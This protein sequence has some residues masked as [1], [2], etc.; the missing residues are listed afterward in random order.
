MKTPLQDLWDDVMPQGSACPAPR[1]RAVAQRVNA[2]LDAVPS[3][4]TRHM[5]QKLKAAAI[6]AAAV[7]VLTSSAFAMARNWTV[8]DAFFG[9]SSELGQSLMNDQ[10]YAIED[11]NYALTVSS[12]LCDGSTA[13]LMVTVEAKTPQAIETLMGDDFSNMRTWHFDF[14]QPEG[15]S[16]IPPSS[17]GIAE[18]QSLR[19]DTSR[20]WS[21]SIQVS[22]G[23][24]ESVSLR[25][26]TMDEDKWLEV[27][28]TPA[29][30]VTLE[31]GA[32][33]TGA[34]TLEH[35]AGGPV[36]LETVTLSPLGLS[37]DYTF[38]T[39]TGEAQP[40]LLFLKKDGTL[41]SWTQMIDSNTQNGSRQSGE[42]VTAVSR[43][44]AFR[45]VQDLSQLKAVVF[46]GIA[47]PLGGGKSYA[48]DT[49]GIPA[50][51]QLPL[52]ERLAPESAYAVPVRALCDALGASCYWDDASRSATVTFRNTT[53]ILTPGSPTALV[54]GQAVDL[55]Y[56]C[57]IQ[58]G[59]LAASYEVF[60]DAWQLDLCVA[61]ED[62]SKEL[63]DSIWVVI[64]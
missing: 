14:P 47:Y 22:T 54:N 42:T 3:E 45:T 30:S 29:Q 24:P 8:L 57:A 56:P 25:L 20:T 31:I 2:A 39:E 33:G 48:V 41:C 27:P 35:S 13:Y 53:I 43:K 59:T 9:G 61:Q 18:E 28:L 62:W 64:P 37:M 19:T 1:P 63:Y 32:E 4:R 23:T 15:A 21:M 36:T 44:Y 12:S 52:M 10:P 16:H 7:L 60:A 11:D 49:S 17:M 5:K 34:G 40:V 55:M 38:P 46:E 6:L 51:F 26:D 58:G 50:P